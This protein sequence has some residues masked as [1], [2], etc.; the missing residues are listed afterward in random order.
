VRF[1]AKLTLSSSPR[2]RERCLGAVSYGSFGPTRQVARRAL[3]KGDRPLARRA[4]IASQRN[5]RVAR[6]ST[7]G[8]WMTFPVQSKREPW[9]GQSHV[10]SGA[11]QSTRHPA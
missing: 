1:E 5:C 6:S 7:A 11:F 9:Q 3:D 10:R 8:P 4:Q 2:Q